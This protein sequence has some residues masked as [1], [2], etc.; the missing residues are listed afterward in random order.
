M[1][2]LGMPPLFQVPSAN[3]TTA[4]E[5]SITFSSDGGVSDKGMALRY[6]VTC[7]PEHEGP[8]LNG[9]TCA[10]RRQIPSQVLCLCT[11]GF[12]GERCEHP[13]ELV[14]NRSLLT[15]PSGYIKSTNYPNN[16]PDSVSSTWA[17]LLE[18]SEIITFEQADETDP[19][20]EGCCDNFYLALDKVKT[21][22]FK[23]VQGHGAGDTLQELG[24]FAKKTDIEVVFSSDGGVNGK[25]YRIRYEIKCAQSYSYTRADDESACKNRG[26][27]SKGNVGE[28]LT[29][30]CPLDCGRSAS[31]VWQEDHLACRCPEG[32]WFNGTECEDVD[33]CAELETVCKSPRKCVNLPGRYKC[34]CPRDHGFL[35]INQSGYSQCVHSGCAH[36]WTHDAAKQSCYL[37]DN[38][39]RGDAASAKE[40]CSAHGAHLAEILNKEDN[41]IVGLASKHAVVWVG[42]SDYDSERQF[43]WMRSS[44]DVAAG[45]ENW[46]PGYPSGRGDYVVLYPGTVRYGSCTEKRRFLCQAEGLFC[47]THWV[48]IDETSIKCY[49]QSKHALDH[50]SA[51]QMC[52]SAA[53]GGQLAK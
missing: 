39:F 19:D 16:Y 29:H 20:F 50:T 14:R 34:V 47:P 18:A 12:H 52:A 24:P 30:E 32:F 4:V 33:E 6:T 3:G 38:T 5:V 25:G 10:V 15:A 35:E 13:T 37:L 53:I 43:K 23:M 31:C 17:F 7:W 46:G 22:D 26:V 49:Y 48:Q 28:T 36:P 9:G 27:S 44:F 45:Y 41:D 11:K 40:F 2:L 1:V 21:F 42:L 51:V 8:C